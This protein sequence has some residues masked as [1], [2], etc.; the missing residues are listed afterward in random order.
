M[1]K[2]LLIAVFLVGNIAFSQSQSKMEKISELIKVTGSVRNTE[3][4]REKLF[5]VYEQ[6][7]P[8]LSKEFW[9]TAKSKFDITKLY[10][11]KLIPIFDKYY[12]EEELDA[13]ITF[14]KSPLG[15]SFISKQPQITEASM[16]TGRQWGREVAESLHDLI[17]K[18]MIRNKKNN[19]KMPPPPPPPAR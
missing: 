16:E 17:M 1:R 13:A 9:Q 5:E 3:Q 19:V 7:F 6:Q 18:E 11:E 4:V 8:Q 10:Q 14:Y 2:G 12:T 15:S